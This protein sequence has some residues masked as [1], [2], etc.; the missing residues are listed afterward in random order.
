[1]TAF[2]EGMLK[3]GDTVSIKFRVG[4]KVKVVGKSKYCRFYKDREG[5][6]IKV[7]RGTGWPYE[8]DIS[9]DDSYFHAKE[10]EKVEILG[11]G[12]VINE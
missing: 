12:R 10:L 1:L 5:T 7:W 8:L 2:Y 3:G 11:S 4:D 9:A 6:V